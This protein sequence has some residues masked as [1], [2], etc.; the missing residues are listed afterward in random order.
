MLMYIQ[1]V[2]TSSFSKNAKVPK[3]DSFRAHQDIPK[4]QDVATACQYMIT[5]P[6]SQIRGLDMLNGTLDKPITSIIARGILRGILEMLSAAI[7][8]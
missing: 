6:E 8:S 2:Q 5:R 1:G 7:W 4:L 3:V